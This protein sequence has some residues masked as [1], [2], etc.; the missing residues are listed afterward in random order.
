LGDTVPQMGIPREA[1]GASIVAAF[2]GAFVA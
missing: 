1:A 2:L